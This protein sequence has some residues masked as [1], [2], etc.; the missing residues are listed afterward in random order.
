MRWNVNLSNSITKLLARDWYRHM[1]QSHE[2]SHAYFVHQ[3]VRYPISNFS[4]F[5]NMYD[6]HSMRLN[7]GWFHLHSV[8]CLQ[9]GLRHWFLSTNRA[10]FDHFYWKLCVQY[11]VFISP[12]Y[13]FFNC[14]MYNVICIRWIVTIPAIWPISR[15]CMKSKDILFIFFHIIRT[16]YYSSLDTT[17][18]LWKITCRNR[19]SFRTFFG[20]CSSYVW[21]T[22][23]TFCYIFG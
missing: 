5:D 12:F 9:L 20:C 4:T 17:V 13:L 18:S 10:N 11:C 1:Y 6:R 16:T 14:I 19:M 2:H 21:N 22:N 15:S 3:S 7:I 23:L 8:L